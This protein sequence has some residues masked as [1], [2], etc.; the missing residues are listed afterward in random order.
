MLSQTTISCYQWSSVLMYKYYS[1]R[2]HS[3]LFELCFASFFLNVSLLHLPLFQKYEICTCV[4]PKNYL[5]TKT[6]GW[7]ERPSAVKICFQF[8][9]EPGN[10]EAILTSISCFFLVVFSSSLSLQCALR[11]SGCRIGY[12]PTKMNRDHFWRLISRDTNVEVSALSP[13]S[14]YDVMSR[15]S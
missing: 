4:P 6:A 11:E 8:F 2:C 3:F 13:C 1:S 15:F 12:E 7:M 9:F 10:E 14:W 5:D